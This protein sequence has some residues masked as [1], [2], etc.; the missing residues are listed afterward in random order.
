MNRVPPDYY[1]KG[2]LLQKLWH[3][4]KWRT[5]RPF[6]DFNDDSIL[7]IGCAGGHITVKMARYIPAA[8]IIGIDIYK[9][10]IEYAKEL[11]EDGEFIVADAH[12]LPFK[13]ETFDAVISTESLE[14]VADP[15]LVLSEAKRVLKRN[16][17][18]VV[19]MDSGNLLFNTVWYLWT[20]LG[21]GRVWKES[22]LT[23]FN[24]KKLVNMIASCGFIIKEEKV[25]HLG[26][27][28]LIKA[29]KK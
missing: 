9:E 15:K 2:N 23:M 20:K 6:L 25:T 27:G 26:M 1:Q 4:E 14:H 12:K 5:L 3:W 11:Y 17:E 7:D 29:E 19:E 22:H 21:R 24:S 8:R 13:N 10:G 18:L 16:G 28:I